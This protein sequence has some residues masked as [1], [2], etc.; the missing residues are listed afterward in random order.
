SE[1]MT[2]IDQMQFGKG[3]MLPK[4]EAAISFVE[5][6]EGKKALITMLSKAKEGIEGKTG[7][8]VTR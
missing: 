2:Y 7:T 8:I 3:S 1:A 5:S 6:G 4:V